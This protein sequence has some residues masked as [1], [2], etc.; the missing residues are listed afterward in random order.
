MHRSRG[1]GV[2][3]LYLLLTRPVFA[4]PPLP[5][6]SSDLDRA[7]L[8]SWMDAPAAVQLLD[9]IE[10]Q[11]RSGAALVQWL[12]ARGLAYAEGEPDK[13][14]AIALHLHDMGRTQ[15]IAAAASHLV[16]AYLYQHSDEFESAAAELKLI[17]AEA[18]LPEFE[19]FRLE[20]VRGTVN[21]LLGRHEAALSDYERAR[22]LAN[23]MHSTSRWVDALTRLAGLYD[24]TRDVDRSSPLVAQLRAFAQQ[25]GDD[26]LW[27]E[28]AD[29]ESEIAD[30]RGDR[31]EQRRAL[32][33]ALSHARRGGSMRSLA[34]VMIDLGSF[35]LEIR[36]FAAA[37]DYSNQAVALARKLRRPMFERIALFNSGMAQIG[38]G[39]LA[40]GKRVVAGAIRQS[41]EKGDLYDTDDE[42]RLFRSA[43][44]Q[45]GDLR[46]ALEV[47]HREES[48]HD[49]LAK[50]ARE[51]ALLELSAKFDAERRARQIELLE[52]DN[53]IKS[54]DLAAQRLRQKMI[55]LAIALIALA[56]GALVWGIARIRGIN[57]RLLHSVQHDVLT[58]WLNRRY[59]SE[60]VL[61]GQVDRPYVGCLLL[62]GLD[63]ADCI[64]E[65]WGYAGGDKVLSAV[66]K[67]LSGMLPDCDALVRWAGDVFLVTTGP[68]SHAEL[69]L[70]VRRL[71]SAT[72]N[73]PVSWNGRCI[74]YT[75]SIGYASFPLKGVAVN[76][77]LDRAVT[78]VG[79]AL[80]Q[81]RIQG[82]GRACLISLVN[83]ADEREL[84]AINAQFE[85]AAL[86]RRVQLV[87]TVS[88]TA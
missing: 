51:K 6:P 4:S 57:A 62:V 87:E 15:P 26:V 23:T 64:N 39:H 13:A 66:S 63:D 10:P 65:T 78:L 79:K 72:R 49:Q 17:T 35:T 61:A 16:K 81:A 48:V 54:R 58:G 80:R 41:Q 59:F 19:R 2:L 38:L 5:A 3:L 9:H 11:A 1:S 21:M 25:T 30:V 77:A 52:R 73:E 45:A 37:L 28:V 18:T 69:H 43:L 84:S 33:E 27:V 46:G 29:L 24:T 8:L 14:L 60:H 20:E 31:A 68:L 82:G 42:L 86:E 67:R 71:L 7:E 12:M 55:V 88:A 32:L 70:S 74:A 83:A 56:C 75:I 85:V 76:I 47:W 40:S 50:T 34:L 44:E 36:S 53:A 22:D